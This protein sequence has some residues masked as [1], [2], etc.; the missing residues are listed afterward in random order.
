MD[1]DFERR[2]PPS[3]DGRLA[4]ALLSSSSVGARSG[5]ER[6]PLPSSA[7]GRGPP[8]FPASDGGVGEIR[9][10]GAARAR[11]SSSCVVSLRGPLRARSS[12]GVPRRALSSASDDGDTR[13]GDAGDDAA[14]GTTS[15]GGVGDSREAGADVRTL[16]TS[17]AVPRDRSSA[18]DAGDARR[19]P[20]SAGG[21]ACGVIRPG[22]VARAGEAGGVGLAGGVPRDGGVERAGGGAGRAGPGVARDGAA[23]GVGRAPGDEVVA[24]DDGRDDGGLGDPSLLGNGT[25]GRLGRLPPPGGVPSSPLLTRYLRT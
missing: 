10:V 4:R 11:S 8:P 7:D 20:S 9:C 23:G 22:G 16:G 3:S 24:G 12:G 18:G 1:R 13:S 15:D 19:E 14:R 2:E 5:G 25:D 21:V 6:R 17:G